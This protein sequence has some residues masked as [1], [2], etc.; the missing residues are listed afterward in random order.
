MR[1]YTLRLRSLCSFICLDDK[2]KIKIGEPD[3]PVALAIRGKKVSVH[4]DETL[5]VGNHDFTKFSIVP[6]VILSIDIPDEISKSWYQHNRRRR[7]GI[8]RD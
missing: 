8:E 5:S 3:Y 7:M 2:H 1:E 4:S 6:S